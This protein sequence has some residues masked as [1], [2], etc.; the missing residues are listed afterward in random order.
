MIL[1]DSAKSY[2]GIRNVTAS[3]PHRLKGDI[4]IIL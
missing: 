2:W 4:N 1:H 3:R